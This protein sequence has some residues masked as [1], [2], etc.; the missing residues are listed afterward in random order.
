MNP[1]ASRRI[2]T[3]YIAIGDLGVLLGTLRKNP[4]AIAHEK[5][6]QLYTPMP[7]GSSG[8]RGET[9]LKGHNTDEVES[10]GL[11]E[12]KKERDIAEEI[13]LGKM[14]PLCTSN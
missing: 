10:S 13:P 6:T 2:K 4:S 1:V 12:K 8:K 3:G 14:A 11:E 9:K 7:D 5:S